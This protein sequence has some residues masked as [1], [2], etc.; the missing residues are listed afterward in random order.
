MFSRVSVSGQ[1][2][3]WGKNSLPPSHKPATDQCAKPVESSPQV[4]TIF[5]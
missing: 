4:R 2:I 1:E 5:I 3:S